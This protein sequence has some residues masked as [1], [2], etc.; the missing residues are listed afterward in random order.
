MRNNHQW[1]SEG[2][3]TFVLKSLGNLDEQGDKC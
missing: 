1:T 3:E 2:Y